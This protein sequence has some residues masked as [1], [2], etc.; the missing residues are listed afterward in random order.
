MRTATGKGNDARKVLTY[1]RVNFGILPPY[2]VLC[3]AP[4][5]HVAP[6]RSIFLKEALPK[7][8]SGAATPVVTRCILEELRT[9]G[10]DFSE[11]AA[12]AKRCIR[13]PCA[14]G[15]TRKS[16]SE[17]ISAF[18]DKGNSSKLILATND[19]DVSLRAMEK[20]DI[21]I[22]NIANQTRLVLRK[23]TATAI[24]N[25]R[26]AREEKNTSLQ[27]SDKALL[28]EINAKKPLKLKLGIVRKRR[29]K[30]PNPLSMKKGKKDKKTQA[31]EEAVK[32]STASQTDTVD[33][34]SVTKASG[35]KRR[36]RR[37]K[38][39]PGASS[40]VNVSKE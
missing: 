11:A 20:C 40:E 10:N 9:L 29:A 22:V 4:F 12:F 30:G 37:G 2:K 15:A 35:R 25:T 1:Y 14:H 17:C 33:A 16:A 18:L 27:G 13:E 34:E 5:I 31:I 28:A 39:A 24:E 8:L 36:K 23:P 32:V 3:D 7:L 38:Q 21:P 26:H 19:T 6:Q